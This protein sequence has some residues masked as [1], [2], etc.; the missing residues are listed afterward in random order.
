MAITPTGGN[1]RVINYLSRQV[2]YWCPRRRQYLGK[3]VPE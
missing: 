1:S 3:R 2:R